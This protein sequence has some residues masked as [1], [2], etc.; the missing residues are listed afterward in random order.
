M[1][2][3]AAPNPDGARIFISYRRGDTAGFASRLY[4]DLT[5]LFGTASVFRDKVKIDPG[6]DFQAVINA[7][8]EHCTIMAVVIGQQWLSCTGQAGRR[9]LDDADDVLVGEVAAALGGQALVIPVLVDGARMPTEEELPESLQPLARKQAIELTDLHWDADLARLAEVIEEHP[10][11]PH[12]VA[13]RTRSRNLVIASLAV[14]LLLLAPTAFLLRPWRHGAEAMTGVLNV[15]V[16]EFGQVNADG[17]AVEAADATRLSKLFAQELRQK[18][19]AVEGGRSVEHRLVGRLRGKSPEA[20]AAAAQRQADAIKADVVISGVLRSDPSGSELALE[21]LVADRQLHDAPEVV[22]HHQLGSPVRTL[23]EAS[24]PGVL[25][26]LVDQLV[27]RTHALANIVVALQSFS[28]EESEKALTHLLAADA[29]GGWTPTD[30]KEVLYLLLG[31][32]AGRIGRLADADAYYVRALQVR[33][34]YP[35]AMLGRAEVLYHRSRGTCEAGTV[36][37]DGLR[38]SA[39]AYELA[40]SGEQIAG[41]EIPTKAAFGEGRVSLCSSQ[42]LVADRWDTAEAR[43]AEVVQAYGRKKET[44]RGLAAEAHAN[45]GWVYRPHGPDAAGAEER[46]R[47]CIE[48]YEIAIG[49]YQEVGTRLDRRAVFYEQLAFLYGRLNDR[50]RSERASAEAGRLKQAADQQAARRKAAL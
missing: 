10:D 36:A 28:L 21:L 34:G 14:V 11:A 37:A 43:F 26:S 15:A 3:K 12:R 48:E 46:Y 32:V 40:R 42:A 5:R 22:G 41:A 44:L 49:L 9:R 6:Q 27:P 25:A 30:G 2:R 24:R 31:N 16:A 18:V 19:T 45:L 39:E 47:R 7:T 50:D 4:E 20:R 33:P 8:L 35:R 23:G 17:D 13:R 38:E 29:V 1:G